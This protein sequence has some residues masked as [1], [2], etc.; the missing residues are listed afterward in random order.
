MTNT[1]TQTPVLKL[2]RTFDATPERLWTFWTDPKKYAKWFNPAPLDLVV[3]EYDVRPGGRIR[4]DMP[5]PDGNPNPQEGVF[6]EVVPRQLLVSG[7]PD[8]SF[9]VTVRFEPVDAKRT[10]LTV[11]V[12]GVPPDWHALATAGWNVGFDKLARELGDEVGV[13]TG[14]TL[15]RAFNAPPEKVWRM[16]TTPEGIRRWWAASAKEMGYDMTVE[17]M[18]VRVG[19]GFAF[20]MVGNGHDL[21]NGGT[22]RVVDPPRRLAWTWHYDIFLAPGEKPYDVPISIELRPV[23]GGTRMTFKQGPLAT[24]E[25]TEG[26]P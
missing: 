3:H 25:F 7:S 10:R 6:H 23:P 21:V 26:S 16:W 15:M 20:R 2:E 24:P 8:R 4:F 18:D 5:Q 12:K 22:Y 11:E 13:D 1:T 14:F 17:R 19:G 9:L